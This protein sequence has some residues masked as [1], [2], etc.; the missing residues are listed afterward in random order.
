MKNLLILVF[1]AALS[2]GCYNNSAGAVKEK[3]FAQQYAELEKG[4]PQTT[5]DAGADAI[6]LQTAAE[7]EAQV[8]VA[9]QK[10]RRAQ[11]P[12]VE[13][14]YIFKIMPDKN[15]YSY[16]EYNQVWNEAPKEKDYKSAKRLWTKPKRHKGDYEP[17]AEA[18]TPDS[19][20]ETP[21]FPDDGDYVGE[22]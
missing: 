19:A 5:A 8:S 14:N 21:D 18:N 6:A 10:E 1:A 15:V 20:P 12:L 9:A 7:R 17:A 4:Q 16:D 13:S 3:S 11:P 2:A 22:E